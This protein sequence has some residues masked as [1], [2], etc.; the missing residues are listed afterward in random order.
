MSYSGRA[1]KTGNSKGFRFESALFAAHPE[2]ASG[3]VEA[4]VI[5]PGRLLVRTRG[6]AASDERVDPVLEA[7]LA[8]LADQMRKHPERVQAFAAADVE[9]LERLLEGV[10]YDPNERLDADFELP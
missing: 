7:F 10:D 1:T 9:G 5:A 8:F 2:F 3:V 4:D 6:D